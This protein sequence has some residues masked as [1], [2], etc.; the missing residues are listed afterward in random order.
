MALDDFITKGTRIDLYI[1]VDCLPGGTPETPP[2]FSNSTLSYLRKHAGA[3]YVKVH[4]VPERLPVP[5]GA[6][7]RRPLH[8]K[9]FA[10][11]DES[12]DARV[13]VGSA[14]FTG[15]GLLGDNREILAECSIKGIDVIDFVERL[16]ATPFRGDFAEPEGQQ[17]QPARKKLADLDPV[18]EIS[19][20]Q[21]AGAQQWRGILK[22]TLPALGERPMQVL[23]NGQAFKPAPT[24]EVTVMESDCTIE[25]VWR[26]GR[27][28]RQTI[29]L[30]I[31]DA[32]FWTRIAPPD[33]R[34]DINRE[35]LDALFDLRRAAKRA[36]LSDPSSGTNPPINSQADG[37]RIPLEQRLVLLARHRRRLVHELGTD[38]HQALLAKWFPS[39]SDMRVALA[40]TQSE[41]RLPSTDAD[42][43][44][45]ALHGALPT[46]ST[47]TQ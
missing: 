11:I 13:F 17:A 42:P 15:P 3:Q 45:A 24:F 19:P 12:G 26:D 28:T 5:D 29:R 43:L 16:D 35:F 47:E 23:V 22:L 38:S 34:E 10:F 8:A 40:I 7:I 39:Q 9:F 2:A 32:E 31:P 46:F 6:P 33:P 36:V 1:G 4:L 41:T 18:F 21:D 20:G 44:I 37:F 14:N 27:R 25:L 30:D